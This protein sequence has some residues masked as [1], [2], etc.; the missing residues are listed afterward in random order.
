M[1]FAARTV[2]AVALALMGLIAAE[3]ATGASTERA[4]PDAAPQPLLPDPSPPQEH[5][6]HRDQSAERVVAALA[7]PLFTP[8]RRPAGPDAAPAA[9]PNTLPRL[10]GTLVSPGRKRA[11]FEINSK[12]AVMGEGDRIDA[13]TVE[14]ISHGTVILAGPDGPRVLHVSFAGDGRV[15]EA[16]AVQLP[17]HF[18]PLR[19]HN[20]VS[21]AARS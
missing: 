4:A 18:R 12:P 20:R 21:A 19:T 10:A 6:E 13:W 8:D 7:R 11:L 9:A 1:T 2:G 17:T 16:Q 3:L 15:Q 5:P 14:A